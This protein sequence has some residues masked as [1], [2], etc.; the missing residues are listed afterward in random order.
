MDMKSCQSIWGS[1]PMTLWHYHMPWE[2][3]HPFTSLVPSGYHPGTVRLS[4]HNQDTSFFPWVFLGFEIWPAIWRFPFC[5]G[6]TIVSSNIR[7]DHCLEKHN[8]SKSHG[9]MMCHG[10]CHGPPFSPGQMRQ[11]HPGYCGPWRPGDEFS[12]E[13]IGFSWDLRV[14]TRVEWDFHGKTWQNDYFSWELAI[15]DIF[16]KAF[17]Q[18][19][20]LC[21]CYLMV[22][23]W[24]GLYHPLFINRATPSSHP[25]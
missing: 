24:R 7:L 10:P 14:F 4:T 23:D 12:M 17:C 13:N 8:F 16:S 25:F 19:N 3:N 2:N 11:R 20:D 1:K 21:S 9:A 15:V 6:G 5:H 18:I 22:D